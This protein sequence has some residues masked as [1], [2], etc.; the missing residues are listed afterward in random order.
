MLVKTCNQIVVAKPLTFLQVTAGERKIIP[1]DNKDFRYLRFRA[2]G[3]FEVSGF[4]GNAD[5]F[6]YEHFEDDRPGYGYKS[7]INKRAHFEHNCITS[8]SM[9]LMEDFSYKPIIDIEIGDSVWTHAGTCEEVTTF[10]EYPHKGS[11]IKL[12]VEGIL[13]SLFFT[14]KHPLWVVKQKDKKRAV[15][16]IGNIRN[17]QKRK[18]LLEESMEVFAKNTSPEWIFSKDVKE[19]DCIVVPYPKVERQINPEIN[20]LDMA[21]F[22]GF[23][24]AEGSIGGNRDIWGD[25]LNQVIQFSFNVKEKEYIDFIKKFA[26]K[27]GFHVNTHIAA[28]SH[29]FGTDSCVIVDVCSS[30][31]ADMMNLYCGRH[32][33]KKCLSEDIMKMPREWQVEFLKAYFEGDANINEEKGIKGST[34]S[35]QLA[36]QI[37]MLCAIQKVWCN[38]KEFKQ[39]TPNDAYVKNC[40]GNLI[41]VFNI[42]THEAQQLF[43]P[44]FKFKDKRENL[45]VSKTD[46]GFLVP[47]K[48]KEE[49]PYIGKVYNLEVAN[50]N[51]YTVYNMAVHNSSLGVRGSI[52][53]LPDAFLNKFIMP[54]KYKDYKWADLVLTK[55]LAPVRAEILNMPNQRDGAIEVLMRI[56][57]KLVKSA[58]VDSKVRSALERLI[59]MIDTGQKLT[60]SMGT[61]V[62]YSTCS[63]CGNEARFSSDYCNHLSQ[64]KKGGL[65]IVTANQIR[66][67][68]DKNT[69]REEWLKWIMASKF[70][71][72][73]VV[74][75]ASNKG[76][77]V[78]N[79]EINHEDSFFELSV[80]GMPAYPQAIQL[81]K[82]ARKS[83]EERD[84]YL[85]R[86]RKEV[87]DEN[88]LDIYSLMQ[89]DGIISKACELV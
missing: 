85:Q 50:Q 6:P 65:S 56:D 37:Q 52:G 53:D 77:A 82:Y 71:I 16:K 81:E 30:E 70:D 27:R 88:I 61:N 29:A 24:V 32:S 46:Y 19:R 34:A 44:Y 4:N 68:L 14:H 80:V 11:L 59:R 62:G 41:Y 87:G 39:H 8:D 23:Y 12:K 2:I 18:V 25:Q 21:R 20:G 67:L 3:N 76:M 5:S 84:S 47:I 58:K 45:A 86:M 38:V 42:T 17:N 54:E 72:E 10:F 48:Y 43:G 79:G 75:G 9:I 40:Y 51:S 7:F 36:L 63:T 78:R 55:E 57:T 49:V 35:Y 69:L 60:V 31:Y 13:R 22:M 66:D 64:F 89:Q 83:S 33:K 28:A 74:K 73:E 15:T 26:E 1:M